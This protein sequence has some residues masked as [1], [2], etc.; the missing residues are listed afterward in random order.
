VSTCTTWEG[1]ASTI[2][3]LATIFADH[4]TASYVGKVREV[5]NGRPNLT[6]GLTEE[7]TSVVEAGHVVDG[8]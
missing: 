6:K 5:R 1:L 4:S 2:R 7:L 8:A 3:E